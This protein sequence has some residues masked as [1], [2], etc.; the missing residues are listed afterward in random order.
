M[1]KEYL[2]SYKDKLQKHYE[3]DLTIENTESIIDSVLSEYSVENEKIIKEILPLSECLILSEY[4]E[5]M[6]YVEQYSIDYNNNFSKVLIEELLDIHLITDGSP[7]E[8]KTYFDML[9]TNTI[10]GRKQYL[11]SLILKI[12]ILKQQYSI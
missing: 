7:R 8:G 3:I 1:D 9:L 4:D 6:H 11:E 10:V 12:E 2:Q 5:V